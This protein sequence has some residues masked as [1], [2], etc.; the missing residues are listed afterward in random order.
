MRVKFEK[1]K[2]REFIKKVLE[3]INYP[4]LRE[5]I[6]RGF[7]VSYC[8]LKNYYSERR[9][10]PLDFFNDLCSISKINKKSIKFK[11]VHENFG[12]VIGG[13][14]SRKNRK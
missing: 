9:N 13:K 4:S 14:K 7:D 6:Q 12:Q 5:L 1:G 8:A 11:I 2:Q 10:L 3:K